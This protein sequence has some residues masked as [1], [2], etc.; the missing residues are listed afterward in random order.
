MTVDI[1]D[2]LRKIHQG[3]NELFDSFYIRLKD[4]G[5]A[6]I[7]C[8]CCREK[9]LTALSICG[10]SSEETREKLLLRKPFLQLNEVIDICQNAESTARDKVTLSKQSRVNRITQAKDQTYK[11]DSRPRSRS[12]SR[13]RR[14]NKNSSCRWC[15][16]SHSSEQTCPARGQTCQKCKKPN[17]FAIVCRSKQLG[18][19]SRPATNIGSITV[20]GTRSLSDV[21]TIAV[22]LLTPDGVLLASV[23]AVPDSG[24][25]ATVASLATLRR[26]GGHEAN[27]LHGVKTIY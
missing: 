22:D 5:D 27:L 21:P 17:H 23:T 14:L 7:I 1:H 15:G 20:L 13:P 9:L 24:A 19:D 16:E 4:A 11:R 6:A 18:T 2:Y 8:D 26:L 3:E 25:G 12:K 10:I